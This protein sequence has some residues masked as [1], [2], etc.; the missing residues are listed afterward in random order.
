MPRR[1]TATWRKR[2]VVVSSYCH[3]SCVM[4]CALTI[5]SHPYGSSRTFLGSGTGVSFTVILRLKYVPSQTVAMDPRGFC[6]WKIPWS[7][8]S[9]S[10]LSQIVQGWAQFFC[11]P[12]TLQSVVCL[13]VPRCFVVV[14]LLLFFCCLFA[15]AL[16]CFFGGWF[17]C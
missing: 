6:C 10:F 5:F 15:I 8:G 1:P 4:V 13:F 11:F 9:V 12:A 3:V 16:S 2:Q 14:C 7:A 17:V